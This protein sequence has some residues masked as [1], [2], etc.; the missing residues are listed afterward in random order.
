MA[1]VNV[2]SAGGEVVLDAV[3]ANGDAAPLTVGVGQMQHY[4]TGSGTAG[5]NL[6]AAGSSELGAPLVT[7]SWTLGGAKPWAALAIA[8]RPAP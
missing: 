1:S 5:G 2:A 6:R 8:I 3:S 7:M 4:N